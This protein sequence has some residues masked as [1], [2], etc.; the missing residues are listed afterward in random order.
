M[1]ALARPL[2]GGRVFFAGEHTN[3]EYPA[4]VHG[5]FISGRR[6]ARHMLRTW[7][8]LALPD[9]IAY[10]MQLPVPLP[11]PFALSSP[12]CSLKY[13]EHCAHVLPP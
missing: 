10:G 11:L 1:D 6:E 8:D 7:H 2:E 12:P 13:R 4:S 3:S 9:P 5:A